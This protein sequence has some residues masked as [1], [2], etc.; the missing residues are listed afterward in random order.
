MWTPFVMP[1][2]SSIRVVMS[3]RSNDP[4]PIN[5]ACQSNTAADV[6]AQRLHLR[7]HQEMR[8]SARKATPPA[9]FNCK[10]S[11]AR[12]PKNAAINFIG[13]IFRLLCSLFRRTRKAKRN[14]GARHKAL[15]N[16]IIFITALL[17]RFPS[18]IHPKR[19]V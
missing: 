16:K 1:T 15:Q 19:N 9:Q 4:I 12:H 6:L 10:T 8:N 17:F 14:N 13:C 3:R 18:K 5:A 11:I 7:L 2:T